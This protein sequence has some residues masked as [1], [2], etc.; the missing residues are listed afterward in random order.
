[1]EKRIV[2]FDL[3]T[4][5]LHY[6]KGDRIIEFAGVEIID[7]KK[8]GKSFSI[9]IN[10]EGKKSDEKAFKIHGIS[11]ESLLDKKTFKQ[12]I[13]E[14]AAFIRGA[15]IVAHNASGFDEKFLIHEIETSGYPESLWDIVEKVT[16]SLVLAKAINANLSKYN[17][18]ALCKH[19]NIDNSARVLHGALI[20]CELLADVYLAMTDGVDL[21]VSFDSDIPRSEIKFLNLKNPPKAIEL[22]EEERLENEAYL[23]D[24]EKEIKRPPMEKA[25]Q[26]R[27]K[28][29]SPKF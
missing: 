3:E 21:T 24:W 11:D 10:P 14:I 5:G 19:Y 1:M 9:R 29:S 4:T 17:L 22:S 23:A 25:N 12:A 16:D 13:P 2:I 26:E 27:P 18:D 6:K 8:T 28:V 15:E 20:D 7:G